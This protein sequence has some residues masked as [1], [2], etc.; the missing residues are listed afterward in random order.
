MKFYAAMATV[1]A[2][3][4]SPAY[5]ATITL[6]FEGIAPHP[7]SSNILI[8]NFYNGGTASNG[9]SGPNLGVAFSSGATLLCLNTTTIQCSNTSKGG[10][11]VAGSEFNAMFF[12]LTNPTMNVAA[13]FDTGFAMSFG[14]PFSAAVTVS[15]F[16]GLNGTGSLL[17]SAVLPGTTNGANGA[18]AA[19][20]GPNYC[21]FSDFSLPF[22]GTAMSVVFGG[23]SDISV[24]DD[25]TFGSTVVGGDPNAGAIPEPST[26]ILLLSGLAA[27][28]ASRYRR[29]QA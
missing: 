23:P 16:S 18:C 21:P 25:F 28:G 17:A 8:N 14:N 22:A 19:F 27:V 1:L 20:G 6:N 10:L 3:A 2:L 29:K 9:A 12:P 4:A 13:G 7:N 5:A 26:V 15:I 11:G 24:Y